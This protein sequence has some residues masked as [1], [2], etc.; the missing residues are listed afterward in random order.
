MEPGWYDSFQEGSEVHLSLESRLL[1]RQPDSNPICGFCAQICEAFKNLPS[2]V[3][4][5]V[6][7]H[8]QQLEFRRCAAGMCKQLALLRLS[9]TSA[10]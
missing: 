9:G 3:P 4:L 6:Y 1:C 8:F 5:K 7:P 2:Q 10:M